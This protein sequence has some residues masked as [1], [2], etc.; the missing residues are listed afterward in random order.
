LIER[1]V[2]LENS[3]ILNF[4]ILPLSFKSRQTD[5]QNIRAALWGESREKIK[6]H[7]NGAVAKAVIQS[8]IFKILK[9]F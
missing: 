3:P 6:T 8:S 1:E 5:N 7:P 2:I 9:Y 4:I